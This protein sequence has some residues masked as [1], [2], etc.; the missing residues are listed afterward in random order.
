M[1]FA[2]CKKEWTCTCTY[3]YELLGVSTSGSY[4]GTI[5][6][7]KKNAEDACNS[8]VS[9]SYSNVKCEIK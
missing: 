7:T 9:T 2:S 4:S 5:K 3:S 1:L 8:S 6:D